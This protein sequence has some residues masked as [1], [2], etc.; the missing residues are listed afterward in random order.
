[1][2][3]NSVSTPGSTRRQRPPRPILVPLSPQTS[4]TVV[5]VAQLIPYKGADIEPIRS[6]ALCQK[7]ASIAARTPGVIWVEW[8]RSQVHAVVELPTAQGDAW[9]YLANIVFAQIDVDLD[10]W[11]DVNPIEWFQVFR[12]CERVAREAANGRH[13]CDESYEGRCICDFKGNDRPET[14]TNNF[15]ARGG[16]FGPGRLV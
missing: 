16:M 8:S 12:T 13:Q 10:G 7:I 14:A 2:T 5:C 4:S 1:M 15:G 11:A 3:S 6:L 9:D